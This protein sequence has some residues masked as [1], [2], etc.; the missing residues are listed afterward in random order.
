[1]KEPTISL[2]IPAY[3]EEKYIG[4]CL[5]YVIKNSNGRF[6]EIIVVDNASTDSTAEIVKKYEGVKIVHENRKGLTRARQCGFE[7]AQGDIL[8]YLDADTRMP[9]GWVETV[10]EEF[11]KNDNLVCLSG[12]AFYYDISKWHQFLV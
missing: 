7:N 5:E 6:L 3:N 4:T 8:A 1:M 12:P 2:I 9:A 10:I 11:N